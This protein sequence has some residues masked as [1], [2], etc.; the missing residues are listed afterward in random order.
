MF[1]VVYMPTDG[2]KKS[3]SFF[4]LFNILVC[5][6][7]NISIA[8][9]H[10]RPWRNRCENFLIISK[11]VSLFF[12]ILYC[13]IENFV[14]YFW[15][16]FIGGKFLSNVT[17]MGE[18]RSSMKLHINPLTMSE[19]GAYRCVAKNSLGDTDGTIKLYSK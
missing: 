18:Y 8:L 15:F 9:S 17:E 13:I 11:V 3:S 2:I 6:T 19:F 14:L 10:K 7:K 12:I 5:C 16:F 4:S 1:E